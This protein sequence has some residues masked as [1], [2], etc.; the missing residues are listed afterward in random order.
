MRTQPAI[1]PVRPILFLAVCLLA[2]VAA[3]PAAHGQAQATGGVN[4]RVYDPVGDRYVSSAEIQL[5]GTGTTVVSEDGGYYRLDNLPAGEVTL[6][7]RYS[8]RPARPFTVQIKPGETVW[9]E[10]PLPDAAAVPLKEGEEVVMLE[11]FTVSSE[12]EGNAK[13]IMEQKASMNMKNVVAADV[14]GDVTEGNVAEFLK[15]MPGITVEYTD[16]DARM[17][18]VRGLDSKY[19]GVTMDGSRL[20]SSTAGTATDARS[21]AFEQISISSIESIEINKVPAAEHDADSVAGNINVRT[22]SAL[23][24]KRMRGGWQFSLMGNSES[25]T[26]GRSLGLGD[27]EVRKIRAGGKFEYSNAFF[28][29]KLG[30]SLS[31][32]YS[33]YFSPS[34]YIFGDYYYGSAASAPSAPTIRDLQFRNTGKTTGR[35]AYSL[36]VEYQAMPEL[37]L[38]LQTSYVKM[39]TESQVFTFR[40]YNAIADIAPGSSPTHILSAPNKAHVD[41]DASA[42][43]TAVDTLTIMPSFKYTKRNFVLDG[44][45]AYSTSKTKFKNLAEGFV[46]DATLRMY[47]VTYAATRAST[48]SAAWN[49]VV[50]GDVGDPSK[51][52]TT[53]AGAVANNIADDYYNIDIRP[54]IREQEQYSG[55]VNLKWV[56]PWRAPTFFKVGGA[57]RIMVHRL[58]S[59]SERY[60]YI[61]PDGIKFT[62]DDSFASY[63][64]PFPFSIPFGGSVS[65]PNGPV[66]VIMPSKTAFA[67]AFQEHPDWFKYQEY[68]SYNFR[69]LNRFNYW[70]EI[71]AAYIMANTKVGRLQLQGGARYEYTSMNVNSLPD[72]YTNAQMRALGMSDNP[73]DIAYLHNKYKGGQRTW[74]ERT[75]DDVFLSASAKW[76]FTKNLLAR[77]GFAQ[78]IHRPDLRMLWDVSDFR[79]ID[80]ETPQQVSNLNL[81]PEYSNN[82]SLELEYYFEPAGRFAVSVYCNDLRDVLYKRVWM[83][84]PTLSR[85]RSQWQNGGHLTIRG[86]EIDYRQAFTSLPGIFRYFG[87][88]ANYSQNFFDQNNIEKEILANGTVPRS[89]SAGI[90]FD[91]R[92]FGFRIKSVWTDD[93]LQSAPD[94]NYSDTSGGVLNPIYADVRRNEQRLSFDVEATWKIPFNKKSRMR[95]TLFISGRNIFNEPWRR[96]S[97]DRDNLVSEL[98]SGATWTAGVRGTF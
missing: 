59:N 31:A 55:G 87:A 69:F 83:E 16:D 95:A 11:G 18:R 80:T 40:L 43:N 9:L 49:V 77:L 33:D 88:Y 17:V 73:K 79:E 67:T 98:R 8:G 58:D 97:N 45:F 48:S 44:R 29:R 90:W 35:A 32:S 54:Q 72:P 91:Y 2:V 86:F 89:G 47:D 65:T 93:S 46:G 13:A 22:R 38:S 37:R 12:R 14:F 60:H 66:Q 34:Q 3:P 64:S 75:Y 56:A 41:A 71:P 42:R 28:K 50:D 84:G 5:E 15:Y 81:R 51:Y 24:S 61:G 96:Y 6:I 70:E 21:F 53:S 30:L 25:L 23:D 4:G 27:G 82:Y 26:T 19:V 92:D 85:R 63:Q 36:G 1:R 94:L 52:T 7:L 62:P 39:S 78:T 20:A 76:S 68:S 74:K 10:M 57:H